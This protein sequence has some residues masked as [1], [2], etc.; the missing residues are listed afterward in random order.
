MASLPETLASIAGDQKVMYGKT[1]VQ[2]LPDGA[3]VQKKWPLDSS[4]DYPLV[5]DYFSAFTGLQ[6][7][8][9]FSFLG[10]GTEN[11][12][13]NTTLNPAIAGQT[14]PAKVYANTTVLTDQL[15]YQILDRAAQSGKQAVMS[16][17]SYTGK[18]MA[19]SMR[20]ILEFEVLHG[21]QGLAVVNGAISTLTVTFDGATTSAGILSTLIGARVMFMQTDNTSARTAYSTAN[22]LTVASVNVADAT[23]PTMTLVATGTTNVAG[24]TTGDILYIGGARGVSVASSD[25]AVPQYE[26]I[27]LG[28][29][30][31]ATTGTQFSINKASYVGWV[32]NQN[33]A[34]GPPTPSLVMQTCSTILGRGGDMGAYTCICHTDFWASINSALATNEQFIGSN[35]QAGSVSKKTGTD[36][37]VIK[38]G[39]IEVTLMPHP[40]QKRGQFYLFADA[41]LHR[42]GSTD[43][44]FQ[45]PGLPD[46]EYH[47]PVQGNALIERQCRADWQMFYEKPPSA[48]IVY[49]ITYT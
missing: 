47:Y 1:L 21:Q 2:V 31:I 15:A 11:T 22:Y 34:G 40:F 17:L 18:Q 14:Q 48:A 10:T 9:G 8:M 35:G 32:A 24:I 37:I 4:G 28:A 12:A 13:T 33:S 41:N 27:G 16:A 46:T 49:G 36:E 45:V 20:N 5:G 26:Q 42:I 29:Q 43:L 7:P 30:F 6:F 19:L 44:T 38:N 3:L 39:G 23:A 25:T